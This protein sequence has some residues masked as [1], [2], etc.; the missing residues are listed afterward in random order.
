MRM[1]KFWLRAKEI[2]FP[3]RKLQI[4]T[5]DCLP[6]TLPQ[7]NLI[8][9]RDGPDDWCIGMQC[10]CGCGQRVELPLLAEATPRWKIYVDAQNR[11][12][13]Q[14]SVWLRDGCRSHYFVREGKVV[15]V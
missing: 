9:L 14:P 10:P 8:L 7:R 5:D 13:L 2:L 3:A 6:K 1:R 4:V 11:P 15:W 12:T